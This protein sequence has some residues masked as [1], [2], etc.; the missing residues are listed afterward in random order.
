M[1]RK[2]AVNITVE[3]DHFTAD[4]PDNPWCN[5]TTHAIGT[6]KYHLQRT[7]NTY[8]TSNRVSI[9]INNRPFA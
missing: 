9:G 4:I 5:H 7:L 6:V 8:V 3:L 2:T 1:I